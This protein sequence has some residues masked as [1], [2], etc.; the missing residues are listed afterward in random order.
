MVTGNADIGIK[1]KFACWNV[2]KVTGRYTNKK[3]QS[4]KFNGLRFNFFRLSGPQMVVCNERSFET[5]SSSCVKTGKINVLNIIKGT[6]LIKGT[7]HVVLNVIKGTM[8]VVL[9]I[10][11]GT[12]HVVLNVIKGT[13]HV[14]LN[15]IKGTMHVV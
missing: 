1:V 14:V 10:I 2:I 9:K 12:M 5:N 7:M 3:I 11:K 13:M 8:H 15:I 6:M 4:F